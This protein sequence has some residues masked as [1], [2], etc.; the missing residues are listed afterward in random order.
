MGDDVSKNYQRTI[1]NDYDIISVMIHTYFF[2][3]V[4]RV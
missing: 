2:D 4:R 3:K 1:S